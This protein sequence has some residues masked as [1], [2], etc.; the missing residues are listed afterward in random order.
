MTTGQVLD[1]KTDLVLHNK[2]VHHFSQEVRPFP[3]LPPS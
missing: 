1:K 3:F 2:V